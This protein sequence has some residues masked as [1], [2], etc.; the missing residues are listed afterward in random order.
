MPKPIQTHINT[1]GH[2]FVSRINQEHIWIDFVIA[3]IDKNQ[4]T[5]V[6]L[7]LVGGGTV[8]QLRVHMNLMSLSVKSFSEEDGGDTADSL[9]IK[10]PQA[11][12]RMR[13]SSSSRRGEKHSDRRDRHEDREQR[14]SRHHDRAEER[15][16]DKH[17]HRRHGMENLE[18][19]DRTEGLKR[20]RDR[21]ER[22]DTHS[23]DRDSSRHDRKERST[24]DRVLEDLRERYSI[25]FALYIKILSTL[26]KMLRNLIYN[27]S[28]CPLEKRERQKKS[29][30]HYGQTFIFIHA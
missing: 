10:P 14:K 23:R 29:L 1:H 30:S 24:G 19:S 13:K 6:K 16:R 26:L 9:D 12:A 18:R 5:N 7:W 28:Y 3:N 25:F 27:F 8:S 21:S 11:A 2:S 15:H 22:I 20:D 17:R 4:I